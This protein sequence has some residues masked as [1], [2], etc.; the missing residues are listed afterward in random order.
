[1]EKSVDVA[2]IGAG[3][4]GLNALSQV[5]KAG[6]SFVLIN[7][8]HW[9]TTCARVG[10]MPSKA[11]IQ[12]AE[13]YH[14]R[15]IFDRH[16]IEG[17]DELRLDIADSMEHVRD[18]RDI[19]VDRVL[20]SS[21][22]ELPDEVKIE[23]YAQFIDANTL[24]VGD[25][26]VRAKRIVIA[27]GTRPIMPET[28]KKFGDRV[29]TTDEVFEQE[30]FPASMAVIGLGVIGL[31]LGQALSRKGVRVTGI[32]GSERIASLSDEVANQT[33]LDI[34]GKEFDIWLGEQARVSEQGER[35]LVTAGEQTVEVDKILVAIGRKPNLDK[36]GLDK[37]DLAL[38]DEGMPV[39]NP[40]TM[41]L[42]DLPIYIAGDVN[43]SRQILHEAG[44]EG[45]IA[46]YNAAHGSSV[47]FKR[48]TPLAI[49]FSDPNICAI[50]ADWSE[51]ADNANT[52]VGEMK[53]GPVGRAL[54]MGKNKGVIRVYADKSNGRV[55]GATLVSVKGE[56]LAHLLAW[57]IQKGL[58]VYEMLRLPFYHPV[59]EEALQ[60]ALYDLLGK[61]EYR[62]DYKILELE[63]LDHE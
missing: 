10:C 12:V 40:N 36:L 2:I 31:E 14:R 53:L 61:M 16:G 4:A 23:G 48:K 9:G 35:L 52:V 51:L 7:G 29:I 38:D 11:L 5:R 34:M 13:D 28:W 58:T 26:I 50:G 19:F 56:H 15:E 54:I 18:L 45:K 39:Y 32:E 37:L 42:G 59:I 8:G 43:G 49:T 25:D 20:G 21:T 27:T 47:A 63:E 33:A 17:E 24:Q 6:K 1:M 30:T 57:S 44:D 55:L 60:A 62:P 22:D 41:Q 3:T 46:G